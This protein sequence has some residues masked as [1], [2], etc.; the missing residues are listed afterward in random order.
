MIKTNTR[1]L[2]ILLMNTCFLLNALSQTKPLYLNIGSHNESND[3]VQY[4]SNAFQYNQ[5]RAA[6]AQIADTII[7]LNARW[8]MQVESN[9][10]RGVLNH[11]NGGTNSQDLLEWA[12]NTLHIEVDPHNHFNALQNPY[13]Y[14][15]LAKL[16]D[17]CGLHNRYNLGGFIWRSFPNADEDWTDYQQPV[18]G[19][20]FPQFEWQ[21]RVIWG[22][23]SP[24]HIDDYSAFGLWKPAGPTPL[25]FGQHEPDNYLTCIG[26]GCS[27]LLRTT[28]PADSIVQL[29][30]D[31]IDWIDSQPANPNAFYTATLMFNFR[32]LNL[33]AGNYPNGSH[34]TRI[35]AIIR[36]LQPFVEDGRLVWA[37]LSQKYEVWHGQHNNPEDHFVLRCEDIV[38]D[39]DDQPLGEN[40]GF[41]LFPNP[42]N[43][44]IQVQK[45][46]V[47]EVSIYDLCGRLCQRQESTDEAQLQLTLAPGC[48]QVIVADGVGFYTQKLIIR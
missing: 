37:T 30:E 4:A 24:G 6:V 12:D 47:F 16:L 23:G 28:T 7:A 1:P 34:A 35:A 31:L 3:P 45:P 43:R 22:G 27:W 32:D 13:N 14:P 20:S 38:L 46:G 10:I 39:A 17:S 9:F 29:V 26:N 18:A 15:D 21:P 33:T 42:A 41:R 40:Q 48:Y 5:A 8:N 11:E 2:F 25:L 36:A 44:Y 19:H